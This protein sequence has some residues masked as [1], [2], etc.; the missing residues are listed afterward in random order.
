MVERDYE[1]YGINYFLDRGHQITIFD[2]SKIIHPNLDNPPSKLISN[3]HFTIYSLESWAELSGL[4][5]V[6]SDADIAILL[7]QSNVLNKS[8]YRTLK[9]LKKAGTPYLILSPALYPGWNMQESGNYSLGQWMKD[10]G[11]RLLNANPISSVLARLPFGI[12]GVSAAKYVIHNGAKSIGLSKLCGPLTK[13]INAHTHDFDLF[14]TITKP[15][16]ESVAS[17]AVFIDQFMPYHPDYLELNGNPLDAEIYFGSL[18]KLFTRIENELQL[19]VVIAAH[20]RADYTEDSNPFGARKIYFNKTAELVAKS[21]LV[22]VHSSTAIGFAV[23]FKKAIMILI[24]DELYHRQVYQKHAY[25]GI[26]QALNVP[27]KNFS[28]PEEVDLSDVFNLDSAAY[29]KYLNNFIKLPGSL[30]LPLWEIIE[31]NVV[32]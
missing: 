14:R 16:S 26:S 10:L 28:S 25:D 2:L 6:I 31:N 13:V 18:Q 30:N 20:P 5:D 8:N 11:E 32:T 7:I 1:R 4:T 19:N 12:F 9:L 22:L 27:L 15:A 3:D 21:Q 17:Q 29:D 23:M 24:T